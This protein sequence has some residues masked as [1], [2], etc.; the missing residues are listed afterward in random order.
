MESMTQG[1]SLLQLFPL[2]LMSGTS[3]A[4]AGVPRAELDTWPLRAIYMKN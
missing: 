1:M 3:N 2:L 4:S